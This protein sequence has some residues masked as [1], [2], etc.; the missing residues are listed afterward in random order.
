MA[1]TPFSPPVVAEAPAH[2]TKRSALPARARGD[3]TRWEVGQAS[4]P[5]LPPPAAEPKRAG[6]PPPDPLQV[7]YEQAQQQGFEQGVQEGFN[8]GQAEY[9]Q[10]LQAIE[11][12]LAELANLRSVLA[13]VYRR[14]MV[15]V[16]LAAAEAL[17]QRELKQSSGILQAMIEQALAA[18]GTGSALTIA[19]SP[20]DAASLAAWVEQERLA[21]TLRTDPRRQLGDF[22]LESAA[23]S[24]ESLMHERIDRVRQLV[25]GELAAESNG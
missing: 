8:R 22:R 7:A 14:E 4:P 24:V 25:L 3:Y 21:V 17:V 5:A 1:K 23:G 18:I 13:E 9:A 2:A 20:A 6:P 16:A 10:Q 11:R 12:S 15:E 19:V